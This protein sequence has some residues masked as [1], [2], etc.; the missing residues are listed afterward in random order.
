[1][2]APSKAPWLDQSE[3]GSRGATRLMKWLALRGGRRVARLLLYPICAYFLVFSPRVRRTSRQYLALA[4]GRTPQLADLWR[5]YFTFAATVLDRVYFVEGRFDR[6]D[7]EV[8]GLELLRHT[9][10]KG[11]GCVLLGAHLGSFELLRTLAP[12]HRLSVNAVMYE[13]NAANITEVLN[14]RLDPTLRE[15]V[16]ASGEIDTVLRIAECFSRGELVGMLGDRPAGSDKTVTCRFF[17]RDAVFPQ[18]PLLLA[19]SLRVPVYWVAGLYEGGRRY[20]I[21]LE[22]FC[23]EPSADRAGRVAWTREWA[24][25]YAE[26]LEHFCRLAPYNWFNFYDFWSRSP[27]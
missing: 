26:R 8:R 1:V 22:P 13:D 4:L 16:I 23:E 9:L 20:V 7:I 24:Q 18:G 27:R 6:F 3:R 10:A 12:E 25:R 2:N 15:R 17:G 21:H 11:R 5:H 19:L 14:A